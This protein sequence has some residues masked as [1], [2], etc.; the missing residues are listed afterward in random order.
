MSI[1]FFSILIF[2]WNAVTCSM[3]DDCSF[4][5]VCRYGFKI[6]FGKLLWLSFSSMYK[7]CYL[8]LIML[9][10]YLIYFYIFSEWKPLNVFPDIGS[11]LPDATLL[12]KSNKNKR[13]AANLALGPMKHLGLM[14]FQSGWLQLIIKMMFDF[15]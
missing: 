9:L 15:L 10:P 1:Y 2:N 6:C 5:Q 3:N 13:N 7:A 14:N 8:T 4:G 12:I 11:K